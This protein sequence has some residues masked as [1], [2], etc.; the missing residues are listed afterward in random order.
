MRDGWS[1]AAD[2][3]FSRGFLLPISG[4]A[5]QAMIS[6]R[7]GYF[8]HLITDNL[9]GKNIGLPTM[10]RWVEQF[11]A[12]KD[13]T[14]V[15]K[16]DWFGLDF[17]SMGDHPDCIFWRHFLTIQV[18]TGGLDFLPL[19]AVRQRVEYIQQYYQPQDE[20]IQ[21]VYPRENIYQTI[22]EMDRS[23]EESTQRLFRIYQQLWIN[24][25]GPDG[26][27]SVLYLV[28]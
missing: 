2:L 5:D 9:W 12:D 16:K 22:P 25:T 23:V 18:E 1:N 11:A 17:I 13:F 3:D 20:D 19:E 28:A 14:W 4:G 26:L 10:K 6:F 24:G 21:K 8:C 15:V 7:L 27:G